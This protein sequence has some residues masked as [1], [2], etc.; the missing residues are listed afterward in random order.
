MGYKLSV[1]F[2]LVLILALLIL[3]SCDAQVQMPSTS[4]DGLLLPMSTEGSGVCLACAQ[5]TLDAALIQEQISADAQAIA[6]AEVMRANSQATLN[7]VGATLGAAQT[8]EQY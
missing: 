8:D 6:T 7:S 2:I 3:A 4:V 1:F 5:A